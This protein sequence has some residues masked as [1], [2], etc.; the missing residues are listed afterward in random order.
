MFNSALPGQYWKVRRQPEQKDPS[1]PTVR[2]LPFT[3]PRT[4]NLYP[5]PPPQPQIPWHVQS[6][7]KMTEGQRFDIHYS[8]ARAGRVNYT[9]QIMGTLF[10]HS[11]S[12]LGCL[13]LACSVGD[14]LFERSAVE[15][16]PVKLVI[17]LL[18]SFVV[19]WVSLF[20]FKRAVCCS[21]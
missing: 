9:W 19:S 17:Y 2:P 11:L 3:E 16:G 21:S 15:A 20:H 14:E 7:R 4:L 5:P 10:R 1:R 13:I 12:S 6:D 8:S 18:P